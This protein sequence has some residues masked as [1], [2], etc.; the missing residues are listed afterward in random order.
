MH[1]DHYGRL[2]LGDYRGSLS[3]ANRVSTTHGHQEYVDAANFLDLFVGQLIAQIAQ[4]A[5]NH[6]FDPEYVRR[7]GGTDPR[8]HAGGNAR[9]Q[10]IRQLIFAWSGHDTR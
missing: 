6:V 10:N 2:Q 7:I 3:W 9:D 4:M 1:G 5:D 8:F